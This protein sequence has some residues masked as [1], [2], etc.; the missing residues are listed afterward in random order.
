MKRLAISAVT[1]LSLI[2]VAY[3]AG[4]CT[5][6]VAPTPA[7]AVKAAAPAVK[8]G[9]EARWNAVLAEGKKEGVV[10]IYTNWPPEDRDALTRSFKEK[11]GIDLEMSAFSN[12]AE[13]IAKYQAEKRAGLKVASVFG[14]GTSTVLLQAKPE[15]LLSRMEPLLI[16]PEVLDAN[17]WLG[18]KLPFADKEGLA[19][20]IIGVRLRLAL[21]NTDLVREGEIT[22]IKDLLKPQYKGK[23]VFFDPSITGAGSALLAH[24]STNIWGEAETVDFFTRLIRDQKAVIGRDYRVN[25]EGVARG[26]YAITVGPKPPTWAEFLAAGAPVKLAELKEDNLIGAGSGAVSIPADFP[27]PNATILF[28]NWLLSKEGQ[29]IFATA[30]GSPS[31][32]VDASAEGIH[33]GFVPVPG[34]KYFTDDQE[35]GMAAKGKWLEV[36]R[37]IIAEAAK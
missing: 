22:S 23:I 7:A 16:L 19:L 37:K 14:T 18:G 34:E 31:T 8:T 11:F 33:P 21:Y 35:S 2:L 27:H 25:T 36:S 26:K 12:G 29:S 9:W 17:A 32:R 13:M 20:S 24:L 1:I 30:Y 10:S 3:L 28:L 4:A 5:S 6:A 15:G